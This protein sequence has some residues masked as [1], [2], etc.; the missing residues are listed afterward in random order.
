LKLVL[1]FFVQGYPRITRLTYEVCETDSLYFVAAALVSGLPC[2]CLL[3]SENVRA[4]SAYYCFD[5]LSAYLVR[6]LVGFNL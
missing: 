1:E 2:G 6:I 3:V 5:L 4:D